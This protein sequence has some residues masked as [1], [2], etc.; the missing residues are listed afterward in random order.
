MGVLVFHTWGFFC[1]VG[2]G[3]TV[4]RLLQE[5]ISKELLNVGILAIGRLRADYLRTLG[6]WDRLGDPAFRLL[7]CGSSISFE[8]NFYFGFTK[9]GN[10]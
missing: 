3:N 2:G 7:V 9:I 5:Q 8:I 4:P 6:S 1:S 10:V